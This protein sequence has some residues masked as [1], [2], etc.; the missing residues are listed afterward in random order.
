MKSLLHTYTGPL[1]QITNL[2]LLVSLG[3]VRWVLNWAWK[4]RLLG[5]CI[6]NV[7]K[8]KVS[9]IRAIKDIIAWRLSIYVSNFISRSDLIDSAYHLNQTKSIANRVQKSAFCSYKSFVSMFGNRWTD[10]FLIGFKAWD[11]ERLSQRRRN[12]PIKW[13]SNVGGARCVG[14]RIGRSECHRKNRVIT[15]RR[16][17]RREVCFSG[18]I[19]IIPSP[20][21][22]FCATVWSEVELKPSPVTNHKSRT[23]LAIIPS[24]RASR[25]DSYSRPVNLQ[26]ACSL[27][28]R[29]APL[30][31]KPSAPL[32]LSSPDVVQNR[33]RS[34]ECQIIL[35]ICV[36][37]PRPDGWNVVW[38]CGLE[39]TVVERD[40]K[41][42]WRV[43]GIWSMV[44]E[45]GVSRRCYIK[46]RPAEIGGTSR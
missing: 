14:P 41:S 43:G 18:R 28:R 44:K 26:C 31:R 32:E 1:Y 20:D 16:A 45:V 24:Q 33:R 40:I 13:I 7:S 19:E 25:V 8:W 11:K 37:T 17:N 10:N 15:A 29:Y 3:L 5:L 38:R 36:G 42:W 30:V 12:L 4:R 6:P 27:T 21:A 34:F 39:A 35:H 9:H 22:D 46:E 23:P 2:C